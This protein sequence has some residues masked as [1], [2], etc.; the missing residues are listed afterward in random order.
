MPPVLRI[1]QID[2]GRDLECVRLSPLTHSN[3]TKSHSDLPRKCHQVLAAP[4]FNWWN[5]LPCDLK[6]DNQWTSSW[7]RTFQKNPPITGVWQFPCV[8]DQK[9]EAE[10]I[11]SAGSSL[12]PSP[13]CFRFTY[14]SGMCIHSCRHAKMLLHTRLHRALCLPEISFVLVGF[15]DY[16]GYRTN[17]TK[18]GNVVL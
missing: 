11:N 5:L 4:G 2:I 9:R 15:L 18:L 14:R 6:G 8:L 1:L 10:M 16:T 13:H 7:S 3:L 17:L 12:L